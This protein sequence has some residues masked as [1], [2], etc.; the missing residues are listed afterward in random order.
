MPM[1]PV[2]SMAGI[3]IDEAAALEKAIEILSKHDEYIG[4]HLLKLA[5]IAENNPAQF[6]MLISMLNNF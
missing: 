3:A 2:T 6:N 4:Q 1:A 5:K